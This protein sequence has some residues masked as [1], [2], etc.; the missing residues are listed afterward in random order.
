MSSIKNITV[1]NVEKIRSRKRKIR[2]QEG[3][4]DT[5]LY[6]VDNDCD[7]HNQSTS[8]GN[9]SKIFKYGEQENKEKRRVKQLEKEYARQ[10]HEPSNR[11]GKNAKKA[12]SRRA[13]VL[14]EEIPEEVEIMKGRNA[15]KLAAWIEQNPE[16]EEIIQS[17]IG[18]KSRQIYG[19]LKR[20]PGH[21]GKPELTVLEFEDN[22]LEFPEM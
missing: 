5:N 12:A 9:R 13:L 22:E 11:L 17:V 7:T 16:T 20:K 1:L 10:N 18:V 3:E 8:G 19:R 21:R 2:I 14:N 4:E 6:Q 15:K